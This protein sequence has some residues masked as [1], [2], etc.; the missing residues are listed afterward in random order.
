MDIVWQETSRWLSNNTVPDFFVGCNNQISLGI[1]KACLEHKLDL[2]QQVSLFSI[3]DV[4]HAGIYGFRFPCVSHDLQE[5]AWQ[6]LNQAI[7]RVT[8]PES[9]AS[10]VVVRGKMVK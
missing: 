2:K 9:K 7:R 10:K 8:D 4:S 3:D 1:I 5:I 6:A